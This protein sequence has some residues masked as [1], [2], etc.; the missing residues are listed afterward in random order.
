MAKW[1]FINNLGITTTSVPPYTKDNKKFNLLGL[2]VVVK[3]DG[4]HRIVTSN[5]T[6]AVVA[7]D[8]DFDYNDGDLMRIAYAMCLDVLEYYHKFKS[9]QE[10]ACKVVFLQRTH[11]PD[12]S[13]THAMCENHCVPRTTT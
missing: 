5:N 9:V 2:Y 6:W 11:E 4:G 12:R 7:K 8:I 3:R 13:N 1:F 10:K